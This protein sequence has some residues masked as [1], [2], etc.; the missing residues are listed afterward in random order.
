MRFVSG[1]MAHDFDGVEQPD[2]LTQLWV[3]DEPPRPLDF[4]SLAAMCDCFAPRTWVRRHQRGPAGTVTMTVNFHA[5]AAL[6]AAQGDR[7]LLAQARAQV[8][9]DGYCDQLGE[10]WSADG[11][12]LAG[13]QQ[14]QYYKT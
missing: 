8:F 12:L 11:Q 6:L 1:G 3:R 10:L 4:V 9:R 7:P 14:I 13:T 2:S 5:D